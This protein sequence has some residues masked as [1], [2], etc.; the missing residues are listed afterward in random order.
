MPPEL[1]KSITS[2]AEMTCENCVFS[3]PDDE[4]IVCSNAR[5][6]DWNR[7]RHDF[8][9]EGQ[10]L[11]FGAYLYDQGVPDAKLHLCDYQELYQEFARKVQG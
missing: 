9:S 3:V 5:S 1:K 6:D 4:L 10:W 8:C 11:W 2:L 7:D